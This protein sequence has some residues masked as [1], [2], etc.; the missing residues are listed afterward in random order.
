ME[1]IGPKG[2]IFTKLKVERAF[3]K[4]VNFRAIEFKRHLPITELSSK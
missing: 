2:I 4:L 1:K 3:K